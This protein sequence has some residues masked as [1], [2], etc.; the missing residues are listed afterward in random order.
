MTE[1]GVRLV[2]WAFGAGLVGAMLA[3]PQPVD[4]WEMPS[5]VLDRVA[6]AKTVRDEEALASMLP[7]GETV[8]RLRKLFLEHG[9]AEI[10]AGY[11]RVDYERRQMRIHHALEALNTAHGPS[12][13]AALRA[14]AVEDYV[15]RFPNGTREP[16]T[17][18]EIGM[19]GGFAS[20]L[21]RYGV[22]D[23]G[24]LVAPRMTVRAMYKARWNLV[25][26]T[27][28]T[29]GFSPIE[30]QAY[31]GW[32]ALHGWG[33]PLTHRIDALLQYKAAG[34]RNVAEAAALFDLLEQRPHQAAKVLGSLYLQ[35]HQ[36]RLRNLELGAV[37]AAA[38]ALR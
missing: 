15:R 17:E 7:R 3:L 19:V 1:S 24:V 25:H 32:L 22:V 9:T 11:S 4:P 31:W 2:L 26:R 16:K 14:Q 18:D 35:S 27:E 5:L 38:T 29:N 6:V 21:E 34:G 37:S 30:A 33:V 23:E 36:L 12:T 8:E 28:A 20:M 13:F 10:A